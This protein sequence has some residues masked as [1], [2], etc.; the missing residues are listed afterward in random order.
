MPAHLVHMCVVTHLA[1]YVTHC[2]HTTGYLFRNINRHGQI[3]RLDQYIT[4]ARY[5]H[6]LRSRLEDI[7]IDAAL[8]GT[9]C[10]RRGGAQWHFDRGVSV[11]FICI[12]GGWSTDFRTSSVWVYIINMVD[13]EHWDRTTFYDPNHVG[14]TCWQCGSRKLYF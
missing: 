5:L 8:F 4:S 10:A 7:G 2:R 1:Y 6:L 12:M 3:S 9:H 13:S 14:P 11:S